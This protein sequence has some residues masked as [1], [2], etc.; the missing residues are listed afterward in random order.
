MHAIEAR[1]RRSGEAQLPEL[2][3]DQSIALAGILPGI[4]ASLEDDPADREGQVH[5]REQ[6]HAAPLHGSIL[7]RRDRLVFEA[8]GDNTGLEFDANLRV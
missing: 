2:I 8:C 1:M 6:G 5:L 4:Q 3:G 7:E